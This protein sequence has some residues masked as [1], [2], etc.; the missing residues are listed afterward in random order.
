M[1]RLRRILSYLLFLVTI[2]P[3]LGSCGFRSRIIL[4][5]NIVGMQYIFFGSNS[6]VS[7]RGSLIVKPLKST[8]ALSIGSNTRIGRFAHI[9]CGDSITIEDNVLIAERFFVSDVT[10]IYEDVR[11]PIVSQ[12]ERIIG[13]VTIGSG[14]W[15][16]ENVVI[17]GVN[18]GKNSIVAANSV[19]IKDVPDYTVVAG[20]PAKRIK[21]YNILTKKWERHED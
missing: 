4:P 21:Q 13:K 14:S 12:G 6:Y 17:H 15:I 2:R 11:R 1:F 3:Q 5:D 16:G 8:A 18:V 9:H 20:N 10:H 19:V 7:P